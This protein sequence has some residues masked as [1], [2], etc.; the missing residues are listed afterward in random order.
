[1]SV[2]SQAILLG[3]VDCVLVL[4]DW[5]VEDVVAAALGI[6]GVQATVEGVTAHV[7]VPQGAAASR[8][9]MSVVAIAAGLHIVGEMYHHMPMETMS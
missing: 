5:V 6:G 2:V 9:L 1:M 8:L 4:E 7:I 3:N